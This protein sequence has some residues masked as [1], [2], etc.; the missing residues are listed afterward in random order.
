MLTAVMCRVRLAAGALCI[1]FLVSAC[2]HH[3]G[4]K[5]R[6][7]SL[8]VQRSQE[9]LETPFFPQDAYQCGP[10][11]LAMVLNSQGVEVSPQ[12]LQA[13][14]YLPQRKGSLQA[15]MLAAAAHYGRLAVRTPSSMDGLLL[16]LSSGNPVIVLQNLG[17]GWLPQWHYAVAIGY[18]LE[19]GEIYLRSGNDRRRVYDFRVFQKSWSRSNYWAMVV[20]SPGKVP[21]TATEN[22]YLT[23]ASAFERRKNH[24]AALQAFAAGTHR[25]SHSYLAW[26]G[27]GNAAHSLSRFS[28]AEQAYRQAL[29][30]RPDQ[31]SLMN[32]LA[33]TLAERGCKQSALSVMACALKHAPDD[34]NLA[35]SHKEI[36]AFPAGAEAC[37]PF[38]CGA[39]GTRVSE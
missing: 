20:V 39:G 14:V 3:P 31:A 30:L 16:E 21:P 38:V 25:W 12:H 35:A 28:Q 29:S 23:A 32:N 6:Y 27:S 22:E 17:F 10:A 36:K 24:V 18:Y 4:S 7:L 33:L 26:A 1:S 11:S 19:K 2:A 8:P 37:Q 9:L 15:E 5:Q 13:L 34:A